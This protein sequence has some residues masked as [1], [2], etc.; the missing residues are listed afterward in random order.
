ML[1]C[2]K[3]VCFLKKE[4]DATF[5]RY[6]NK[7]KHYYSLPL[8]HVCVISSFSDS[9]HLC[10]CVSSAVDNQITADPAVKTRLLLKEKKTRKCI[11]IQG[12][13]SRKEGR[14]EI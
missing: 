2:V 14:K 13:K 1:C 8:D 3:C 4:C 11:Q 6:A 7:F 5:C 9:K 12:I 10:V